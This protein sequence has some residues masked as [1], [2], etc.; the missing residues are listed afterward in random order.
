MTYQK[1]RSGIWILDDL[2]LLFFHNGNGCLKLNKA[3]YLSSFSEREIAI[4]ILTKF[5]DFFEPATSAE[6]LESYEQSKISFVA[7]PQF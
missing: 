2:G 6:G 7:A 4:E 5:P 1:V 3:W